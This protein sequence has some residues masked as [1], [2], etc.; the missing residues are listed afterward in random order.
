MKPSV[1]RMWA[2]F[3]AA[4]ALSPDMPLPPVWHF[5]DTEKEADICAAL[6]LAGQKRAT[7]PSLW[8]LAHRGEP[9]PQVGD[10]D[11]VTTW[12]GEARAII[13]TTRVE[14][15]PFL[16]VS[17]AHATAEGEGDG[18]LAW[19]RRAHRAYYERELAGT[20]YTPSDDMPVVCQYFEIA[21]PA[22]APP[23]STEPRPDAHSK[24]R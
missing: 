13:R 21:Y 8:G 24:G 18:S 6:V 7:A 4:G 15:H 20:P 19:W 14:I 16:E 1:Y 2:D 11:V 12:D 22:G 10:L 9:V 17:P 5:C 23:P 3:R